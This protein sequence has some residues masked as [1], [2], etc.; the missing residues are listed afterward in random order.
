MRTDTNFSQEQRKLSAREAL[1]IPRNFDLMSD[2][3]I[4]KMLNTSGK[5]QVP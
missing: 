3:Q 4:A 5:Y 2:E 1:E